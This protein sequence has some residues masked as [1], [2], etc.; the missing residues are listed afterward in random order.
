MMLEYL[1]LVSL[2]L[3]IAGG[4]SVVGCTTAYGGPSRLEPIVVSESKHLRRVKV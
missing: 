3:P 4:S 1:V 2:A